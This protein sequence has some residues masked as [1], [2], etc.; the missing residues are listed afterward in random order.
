MLAQSQQLDWYHVPINPSKG[1]QMLEYCQV[2]RG[3]CEV[4]VR[5]QEFQT[6]IATQNNNKVSKINIKKN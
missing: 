5:A 1:Q 2:M 4:V 6:F 3:R